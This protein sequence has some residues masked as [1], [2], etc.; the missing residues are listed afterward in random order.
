MNEVFY[1]SKRFFN[2]PLH[3]KMKLLRNEKHRGYTPTLDQSLDPQNQVHG[4][5][6][7][8]YFIGREI[9][10][11]DPLAEK[12][13]FGPNQWPSKDILPRW[14][15]V[16]EQYH[17][18]SFK[19]ALSM[20]KIIALA[21]DLDPDFFDKPE[22]FGEPIATLRLLHYEGKVSNPSMGIFGCGAHSDF[23]FITLLTTD[24]VVGLQCIVQLEINWKRDGRERVIERLDSSETDYCEL[25]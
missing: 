8:G 6:K 13:F 23:G 14:R 15:Q 5:Y 20:A 18:D 11:D 21:L 24:D 17:K 3:E 2:L 22:I 12:P 7:E 19:V 16:M 9:P 10:E 25:S 4:D 1:E